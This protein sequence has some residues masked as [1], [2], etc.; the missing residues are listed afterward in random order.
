MQLCI[1]VFSRLS[2]H[3]H[4]PVGSMYQIRAPRQASIIISSETPKKPGNPHIKIFD[5]PYVDSGSM[6]H[7]CSRTGPISS[8]STC[9][10][11]PWEKQRKISVFLVVSPG[12]PKHF[13]RWAAS[14]YSNLK[15]DGERAVWNTTKHTE[16]RTDTSEE[17]DLIE[18]S[19]RNDEGGQGYKEYESAH[20]PLAPAIFLVDLL[21]LQVLRLRRLA[22][23]LLHHVVLHNLSRVRAPAVI[24]LYINV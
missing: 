15:S 17:L 6:S 21:V 19:V 8:R 12:V 3:T 16:S 23:V 4:T 9:I 14:S 18:T 13:S 2:T 1:Y 10:G 11:T 20:L 7:T 22:L 5:F 24:F